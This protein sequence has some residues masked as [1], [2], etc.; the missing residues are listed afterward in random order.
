MV[1]CYPF[2]R[3]AIMNRFLVVMGIL[4][5]AFCYCL[6]WIAFLYDKSDPMSIPCLLMSHGLALIT[7]LLTVSMYAFEMRSYAIDENGI[8]IGYGYGKLKKEFHSRDEITSICVCSYQ[9][10]TTSISCR[11]VIWCTFG[12]KYHD[13]RKLG[14]PW[15]FSKATIHYRQIL[16]IQY[17]PERLEGFRLCSH[18]EIPDYRKESPPPCDF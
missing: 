16:T 5:A 1:P 13:P 6:G 14:S 17:T 12:D 4:M 9:M 15:A 8:I 7:L 10:G 2:K 18:R 3:D 11:D